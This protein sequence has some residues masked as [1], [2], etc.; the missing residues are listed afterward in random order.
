MIGCNS[1]LSQQ[2]LPLVYGGSTV[3]NS[4]AI[5]S[6]QISGR[7]ALFLAAKKR[8]ISNLASKRLQITCFISSVGR[9]GYS[10]LQQTS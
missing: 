2:R 4:N 10:D 6:L 3:Y 7:F 8:I 1:S 9:C 5:K